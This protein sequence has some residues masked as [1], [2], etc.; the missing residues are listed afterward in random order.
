MVLVGL[1]SC[2][3]G[4]V[5][6]R[7]WVQQAPIRQLRTYSLKLSSLEEVRLQFEYKRSQQPYRKYSMGRWGGFSFP[8]SS[9]LRFKISLFWRSSCA[10][11]FFLLSPSFL[12]SFIYI[13]FYFF[14]FGRS[15]SFI[16]FVCLLL[17]LFTHI[18]E[19]FFSAPKLK[20]GGEKK[21]QNTTRSTYQR[22]LPGCLSSLFLRLR[23][24][25]RIYFAL[26]LLLIKIVVGSFLCPAPAAC[27]EF[28]LGSST[29][30]VGQ[31]LN[32]RSSSVLF[33]QTNIIIFPTAVF[34]AP[35]RKF[36]PGE[37]SNS[38]PREWGEIS[39]V[40]L[41]R[42]FSKGP[43]EP[44]KKKQEKK[45]GKQELFKIFPQISFQFFPIFK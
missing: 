37:I 19:N 14:F 38:P 42:Y 33:R 26:L 25:L 29:C 16:F 11:D 15:F 44:A 18:A 40:P 28:L 7:P 36:G 8:H 43:A 30:F 3:A 20:A 45:W 32:K 23:T 5:V 41:A 31:F 17:S 39:I 12:P 24:Y 35:K 4:W 9:L 13:F 21:G 22:L 27:G 34:R 6:D 2:I 1:V 10:S